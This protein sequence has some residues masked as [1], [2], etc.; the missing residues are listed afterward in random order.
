MVKFY[1][2]KKKK[3]H[4]DYNVILTYLIGLEVTKLKEEDMPMV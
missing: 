4:S 1:I 3:K 2:Q